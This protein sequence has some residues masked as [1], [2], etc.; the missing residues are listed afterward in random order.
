MNSQFLEKN[1]K[2]AKKLKKTTFVKKIKRFY[3]GG[4]FKKLFFDSL[5]VRLCSSKF[6]GGFF[7]N[8]GDKKL[9]KLPYLIRKLNKHSFLI[10]R[11]K[12]QYLGTQRSKSKVFRLF[13][14]PIL[15]LFFKSKTIYFNKPIIVNTKK[16]KHNTALVRLYKTTPNPFT[17]NKQ[18]YYYQRK[19]LE[20]GMRYYKFRENS[21]D[22][23]SSNVFLLTRYLEFFGRHEWPIT[24]VKRKLKLFRGIKNFRDENWMAD[25]T[26]ELLLKYR[27]RSLSS[28]IIFRNLK[29][30]FINKILTLFYGKKIKKALNGKKAG[31][32]IIFFKN[33]IKKKFSRLCQFFDR[34][35]RS[36]FER[37]MGNRFNQFFEQ[38]LRQFTA[39]DVEKWWY[40]RIWF[41]K[42]IYPFFYKK[43]TRRWGI[44]SPRLHRFKSN[45]VMYFLCRYFSTFG[46]PKRR[47]TFNW[48]VPFRLELNPNSFYFKYK[49]I[50]RVQSYVDYNRLRLY[51]GAI[52]PSKFW[53][54]S[55]KLKNKIVGNFAQQHR[56]LD[57]RLDYILTQLSLADNIFEAKKLVDTGLIV[58]NGV[59]VTTNDIAAKP[60]QWISPIKKYRTLLR[61]NFLTRLIIQR[62]KYGKIRPIPNFIEFNS[63]LFRFM[64][65]PL[66]N[67]QS[68]FR[69]YITG[70]IHIGSGKRMP[71]CL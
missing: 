19:G 35:N 1:N 26:V 20:R 30:I 70:D 5:N 37:F 22:F 45:Y 34:S 2:P 57:L 52:K 67:H 8:W 69:P 14:L 32:S 55:R 11:V 18:G 53:Q 62:T 71:N 29:K 42:A 24:L 43:R 27:W 17:Y 61:V 6:I 38:C 33:F 7:E 68:V 36:L 15:N 58:S 39:I 66:F 23:V 47:R 49:P 4:G 56:Y 46:M 3:L 16:Y 13:P 59:I 31:R 25:F 54:Y 44:K 64:L 65:L 50:D 63:S 28:I 60:F 40:M 12:N 9:Y 10:S 51:F 21:D 48:R 41:E